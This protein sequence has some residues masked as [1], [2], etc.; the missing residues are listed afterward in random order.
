MENLKYKGFV[1]E[2]GND[3]PKPYHCLVDTATG[4]RYSMGTENPTESEIMN[5]VNEIIKNIA[6]A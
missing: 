1:Y 5:T 2:Y 3:I 6:N 4:T